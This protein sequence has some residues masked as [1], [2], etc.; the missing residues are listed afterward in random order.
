MSSVFARRR[1][2]LGTAAVALTPG[3]GA[4]LP[5]DALACHLYESP[6]D[7]RVGC[8]ARKRDRTNGV[9][10]DSTSTSGTSSPVPQSPPPADACT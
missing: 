2:L 10:G 5:S 8:G 6:V 7:G 1:I 3:L 4:L 9:S